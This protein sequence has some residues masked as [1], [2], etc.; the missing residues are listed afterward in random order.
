MKL[1]NNSIA[2]SLLPA[3]FALRG[4]GS[5]NEE[6]M[7]ERILMQP[8]ETTTTLRH[9]SGFAPGDTCV[10]V[11]GLCAGYLE[12]AVG[13]LGD[14]EDSRFAQASAEFLC[15]VAAVAFA[16]SHTEFQG[17]VRLDVTSKNNGSNNIRGIELFSALNSASASWAFTGTGAEALAGADAKAY[18]YTDVGAFCS[19]IDANE[20][21][22][23]S[24]SCPSSSLGGAGAEA[25]A[26]AE[27]LSLSSSLAQ[28][29]SV[30]SNLFYVNV[31]GRDIDR[32]EAFSLAGVSN[33]ANADSASF[34]AALASAW[35]GAVAGAESDETVCH[36][37]YT[38]Y[39][40]VYPARDAFCE[41]DIDDVCSQIFQLAAANAD[42][43][44]LSFA[45]AG[46]SASASTEVTL[47]FYT[48]VTGRLGNDEGSM[49]IGLFANE[50]AHYLPVGVYTSCSDPN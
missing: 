2:I 25:T 27:A 35:A 42:A 50:G 26:V 31:E 18:I 36:D 39:C 19:G 41:Q 6:E 3:A 34:S 16:G 33:F 29:L 44:A 20:G 14:D 46:A 15:S 48:E 45:A 11:R 12:V 10:D 23:M 24:R 32:F 5:K 22:L 28:S 30:T 37:W 13:A 4:A 21:E 38:G 9:I 8:T 40:E 1:I 17:D 43:F 7:H 49:E 47:G